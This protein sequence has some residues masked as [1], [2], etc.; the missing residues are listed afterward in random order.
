VA[1]GDRQWFSGD[2]WGFLADRSAASLHDLLRPHNEHW[3][4]LPILVYRGLWR[5]F[6]LRTYVP[7]Q[8]CAIALHLT[9]AT[10]LLVIMRRAQVSPWIATAA[11]TAFVFLGTG[12]QNILWAFQIGFVGALVCGFAHLLLADHDGRLDRR[13]VLALAFGLAGLLCSGVAVTMTIVVGVAM[14]VRRGWRI[15]AF[16]TVPL[17]VV[18]L[19]WWVSY[20]RGGYARPGDHLPASVA[21]FVWTGASNAFARMG[22]VPGVGILLAMALIGGL[23]LAWRDSGRTDRRRYAAPVALCL[24]AVVFLTIA[25]FGRATLYGPSFARQGRY[26]HIVVALS[27]PAI[28]VAAEAIALR[29]RLA[30]PLLLALLLTGVPGN[31]WAVADYPRTAHRIPGWVA[32]RSLLRQSDRAITTTRCWRVGRTIELSLE[33]RQSLRIGG[34]SLRVYD[35][36]HGTPL[37]YGLYRPEDGRTLTARSRALTLRLFADSEAHPSLVCR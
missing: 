35:V 33:P 16:H 28:A 10:L 17:G 36:D 3:S 32:L 20:G 1:F 6:G 24:G 14:L 8:L 4:T 13:D 19:A 31:V 12:A 15:A 22:Q 9:A 30:M 27:L 11:A 5:L 37:D 7:Y 25:A 26:V 2:D 23:V 29:W 34:G 21:R 18:Y